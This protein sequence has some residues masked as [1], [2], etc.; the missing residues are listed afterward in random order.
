MSDKKRRIRNWEKFQ[1][2]QTGKRS[3]K[4]PDWIKL[5]PRL[6]NDYDYSKLEDRARIIL[7]E[8]F[9]LASEFGG[10]LP[11]LGV[12][13]FRLRRHESEVSA[14]LDRLPHWI[15][16]EIDPDSN[17]L[18]DGYQVASL[19]REESKK[20]KE[21]ERESRASARLARSFP[22]NWFPENLSPLET[23]EFEKFRDHFRANGKR[24]KD[25]E[26]AWRNWKRR[27]PEF[28]AR[29]S[30]VK[31]SHFRACVE[32]H[33]QE[34]DSRA[35]ELG[36]RGICGPNSGGNIVEFH[37]AA[38]GHENHDAVTNDD[39]YGNGQGHAAEDG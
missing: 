13:A 39:A 36:R 3:E 17:V 2:Y 19:D 9:M 37:A 7:I 24:M 31:E 15:E 12:I 34:V 27:A 5:Y 26:A 33:L 29:G 11:P 30:P 8:L 1:H 20:E 16:T 28:S 4:A 38:S 6:L 18:A 22:E 35:N 14:V 23:S 25:W 10:T 32:K 21:K